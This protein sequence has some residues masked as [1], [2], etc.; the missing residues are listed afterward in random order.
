MVFTNALG[1][2]F[3]ATLLSAG[4]AGAVLVFPEDG[5][6]NTIAFSQLSADTVRSVCAETGFVLV[7][8]VVRP[9]YDLAKANLTSIEAQLSDGRIDAKAAEERRRRVF[10]AF[11]RVCGEKGV[12]KADAESLRRSL[13]GAKPSPA[14]A[15]GR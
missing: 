1:V 12:G 3:T 8:G 5:A 2:A 13:E 4:D 14:P 10:D 7:P 11:V 9:A 15:S 6:S